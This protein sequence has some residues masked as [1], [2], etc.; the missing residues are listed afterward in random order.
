M[1][2]TSP[3][4]LTRLICRLR[5]HTGE[6]TGRR[7]AMLIEFRCER[8]R[9]L[10]VGNVHPL[11]CEILP[12]PFQDWVKIRGYKI[13]ALPVDQDL[14]KIFRWEAELLQLYGQAGE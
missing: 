3:Q 8:C 10:L 2:I 7:L 4:I 1:S 9:R 14:E 5:G 6:L 12:W 11:G 13:P